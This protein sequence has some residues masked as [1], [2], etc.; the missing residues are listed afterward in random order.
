MNVFR[1]F[2]PQPK[3][4]SYLRRRRW[5]RKCQVVSS[6]P[7]VVV[8]AALTLQ[9]VS[10]GAVCSGVVPLWAV[11]S[12]GLIV[13]RLGVSPA[14]PQV[15]HEHNRHSAGRLARAAPGEAHTRISVLVACP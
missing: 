12:D 5:L 11:T 14:L 9:D 4:R 13:T 8:Q 10:M 7:F 15:R 3:L 2:Y 1:N 6:G